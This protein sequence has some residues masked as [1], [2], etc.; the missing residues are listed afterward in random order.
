MLAIAAVVAVLVAALGVFFGG[1]YWAGHHAPI[2]ALATALACWC[3]QAASGWRFWPHL[4][5]LALNLVIFALLGA[6]A[7]WDDW[8]EQVPM[9][10]AA[11]RAV[12]LASACSFV[13]LLPL[14]QRVVWGS[15]L[16]GRR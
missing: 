14:V 9:V 1:V 13:G 12:A 5:G 4:T 2:Y 7:A 16:S 3:V 10:L 15:R 8:P 6:C 11:S